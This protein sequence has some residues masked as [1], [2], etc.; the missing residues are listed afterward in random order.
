MKLR[1]K[2]IEIILLVLS[3]IFA[4]AGCSNTGNDGQT[5]TQTQAMPQKIT[6]KEA[7]TMM[8]QGSVILLDVR[9]QQE[10]EEGH[11]QDSILLPNDQILAKAESM[12][13]DKEATILVYCRTGNRSAQASKDLADLGYTKVYDF[14]GIKDWPYE[15]VK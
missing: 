5:Q 14:G 7:K 8:D 6:A 9:T 13:A 11:I 15:I 12:L 4:L 10:F 2:K 3:L 1:T